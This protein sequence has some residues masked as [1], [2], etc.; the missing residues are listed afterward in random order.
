[1]AISGGKPIC[2]GVNSLRYI[3]GK[4]TFLCSTHA[5]IHLIKKMGKRIRGCKIYVYRFNNSSAADAREV[6]SAKPCMLCQHEL[7]NAGVSRVY[8]LNDEGRVEFMKNRDMIT[9]VGNPA[10]LTSMFLS[11][12]DGDDNLKFIPSDYIA[13]Q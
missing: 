3:R 5:E 10:V 12:A 6:K 1:M 8:Y 11:K 2:V 9:L 13:A 4:S 7:K